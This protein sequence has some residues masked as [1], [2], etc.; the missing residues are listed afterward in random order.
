[1]R[2]RLIV[3]GSESERWTKG[4]GSPAGITG[5]GPNLILSATVGKGKQ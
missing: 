4:H 3:E 2:P 5:W 1:M